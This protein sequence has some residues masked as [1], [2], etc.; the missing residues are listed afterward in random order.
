MEQAATMTGVASKALARSANNSSNFPIYTDAGSVT[1]TTTVSFKQDRSM[2][3]VEGTLID[4][5]TLKVVPS[6]VGLCDKAVLDANVL[7]VGYLGLSGAYLCKA[8]DP[9]TSAPERSVNLATSEKAAELTGASSKSLIRYTKDS[10]NLPL[11]SDA[12]S[13]TPLPTTIVSFKQDHTLMLV[14]GALIDPANLKVT[15]TYVGLCTKL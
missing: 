4:P 15:P 11:Y 9:F 13:T 3:L 2:M 12:A 10:N 7:Q 8:Q 6:Y 5:V 14:E 1:I